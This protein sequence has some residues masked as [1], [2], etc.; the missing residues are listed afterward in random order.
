[1]RCK[2]VKMKR[3]NVHMLNTPAALRASK[4]KAVLQ[5][6]QLKPLSCSATMIAP[7]RSSICL[8]AAVFLAIADRS[9]AEYLQAMF[10]ASLH[11]WP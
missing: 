4:K 1:M 7:R 8:S 6:C 5:T 2:S 11:V 9:R 3:M 10:V